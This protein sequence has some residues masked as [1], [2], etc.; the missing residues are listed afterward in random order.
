MSGLDEGPFSLDM[1]DDALRHARYKQS[2]LSL[3]DLG[4]AVLAGEDF[5]RDNPIRRWWGGTLLT[6]ER[7]W[8]WDSQ[9]RLL[10]APV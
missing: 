7:L 3:T 5:R 1:H 6:N 8:R 4:K 10:V 9:T 2:R